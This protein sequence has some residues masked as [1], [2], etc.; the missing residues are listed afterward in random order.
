MSPSS[1]RCPRFPPSEKHSSNLVVVVAA[2][3]NARLYLLHNVLSWRLSSVQPHWSGHVLETL[4]LC[5]A[6]FVVVPSFLFSFTHTHTL[7]LS[8]SLRE[9]VLSIVFIN[10]SFRGILAGFPSLSVY[11]CVCVCFC[12]RVCVCVCVCECV[13]VCV[14]V[15]EFVCMECLGMPLQVCLRVFLGVLV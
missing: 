13:C 15:Q 3:R 7:S 1:S 2:A 4:R 14:C 11:V 10:T 8:L 6:L 9:C 12:V 5:R